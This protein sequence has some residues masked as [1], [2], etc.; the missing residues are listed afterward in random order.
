MHL[1][2]TK[3][4]TWQF[5]GFPNQES[6]EV[7]LTHPLAGFYHCR[8]GQVGTYRVW[9][10]KLSPKPAH[11]VHARFELLHRLDLVDFEAQLQPYSVLIEPINA[12]T[13]YLPPQ[14][15]SA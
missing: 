4:D 14:K 11:L 1:A 15:I 12:F 5:E 7:F 13:V 3:Y 2:Q 8:N 10:D 9:H 6:H